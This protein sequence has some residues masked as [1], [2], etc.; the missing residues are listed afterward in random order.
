MCWN[1][2]ISINTFSFSVFVLLLIYYN[3]SSQS[4][5]KMVEFENPYMYLFFMSFVTMQFI[6]FVLWRNLSHKSINYIFSILGVTLLAL[7]PIA[8]ILLVTHS[9]LRNRLLWMYG[10]PMVGYLCY[11]FMTKSLHT[12]ISAKGHLQWNWTHP[13]YSLLIITTFYMIFLYLPLILNQN[14]LAMFFTL[15][16]FT[17]TY[18][19]YYRDGSAGSLW[20]WSINAMM[21]FLI[22]KLLFYLPFQEKL[23]SCFLPIM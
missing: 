22:T 23:K 6:E 9:S 20:C 5:Y 19:M 10:L 17:I 18:Y 1:E 12:S 4:Q 13:Q 21:I 15:S 3:N 14:Y 2:H 11:Q 8:S 16:L 7:Q